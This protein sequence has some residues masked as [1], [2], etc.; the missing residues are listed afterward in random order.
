[1]PS[2]AGWL[3][4]AGG[5]AS[6]VAGRL[7]ALAELSVLG[8]IAITLVVVALVAVRR[9]LPELVVERAVIPR[10]VH[11]GA[12]SRVELRV[13]NQGRRRTPLLALHDPVEG[14]IGARVSLAPVAP[15]TT[16]SASYR[17]PTDRRGLLDIGPLEARRTDAFGLAWRRSEVTGP[18][19]LTVLPS[20]EVLHRLPESAGVDDPL[21]GVS[22]SVLGS[23]GSGEFA[24]L[25]E[26]VSGDDLRRVHWPSS[27]RAGDL[28]VREED[29][30]WQGHLTVLLDARASHVSPERFEYAVTGAAS[31]VHA[32]SRA[33]DRIRLIVSDGTDTGLV[34][35][36][37]A[38]A[39]LLE[40]L[41]L[42]DLHDGGTLPQPPL[43]GRR[44]TGTLIVITGRADD[45]DLARIRAVRSR[46][47]TVLVIAVEG[48]PAG[49]VEPDLALAV[50]D[51]DRPFGVA[52]QDL[53][54]AGRR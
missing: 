31:I 23:P 32:V 29:P 9:P 5:I 45:D 25:R 36:R 35:A 7:L 52:W 47:A 22:R 24:S 27:A 49:P 3:V 4:A 1:M 50:F 51:D 34:D 16:H 43:D 48:A 11:R 41:A 2:R 6:I 17:L 15:G 28:L 10:R 12:E 18:T 40:H 19:H 8:A 20:V 44:R 33:V 54:S 53:A 39:T 14:T 26:Y 42:V 46:F 21:A 30:P 38:R 37:A 13:T